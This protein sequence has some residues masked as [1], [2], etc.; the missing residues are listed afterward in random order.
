MMLRF[1]VCLVTHSSLTCFVVIISLYFMNHTFSFVIQHPL[2]NLHTVNEGF[3]CINPSFQG[4][5]QIKSSAYHG[6]MSNNFSQYC[7]KRTHQ[8]AFIVLRFSPK[9]DGTN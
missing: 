9:C 1:H 2:F 8:V 7:E 6:G 4:F 3:I 5:I